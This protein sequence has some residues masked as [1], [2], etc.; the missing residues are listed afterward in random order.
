MADLVTHL[1]TVLLPGA[2]VPYRAVGLV[3]LGTVVP[4]AFG[5]VVPMA[6]ELGQGAGLPIPDPF[7]WSFGL[8]HSPVG[9]TLLCG[10]FALSFVREHRHEAFAALTLGAQIHLFIDVLQFHHGRGYPLLAPFS[11]ET[12]ELGVIGSEATVDLA[13]PLLGATAVAWLL[14]TAIRWRAARRP[15]SEHP[16]RS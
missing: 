5:R 13:L 9:A 2:L 11:W 14:R 15:S 16:H 4:D 10:A 6:L 1:C 8:F 12:Y 3:A 7:V